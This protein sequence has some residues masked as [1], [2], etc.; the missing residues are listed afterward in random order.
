MARGIVFLSLLVLLAAPGLANRTFVGNVSID[1]IQ[2]T[3]TILAVCTPNEKY[4]MEPGQNMT[5]RLYVRNAM[6]NK[7]VGRIYLEV[8]SDPGFSFFPYPEHLEDIPPDEYKYFDINVSADPTVARGEHHVEF[9]IGTDEYGIGSHTDAIM[10]R[11]V[12]YAGTFPYIFVGIIILISVAFVAR[13]IYFR[14][15]NRDARPV[16]GVRR[17]RAAVSQSYYKK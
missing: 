8:E 5:L 14:K 1:I 7:T 16:R 2:P 13:M 6:A 3:D 12:P 15:L 4:T 10:I 9:L 11:I 17:R